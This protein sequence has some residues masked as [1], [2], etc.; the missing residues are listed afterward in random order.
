MKSILPIVV[1]ILALSACNGQ[2][3][4]LV[5]DEVDSSAIILHE[6][7][8]LSVVGDFSGNGKAD[9]IV[10]HN[11]SRLRKTEIDSSPDPQRND[12]DTVVK[13]FYAEDSELFLTS[14]QKMLD[15]L[16]LGVAQGL[17]CLLNL[18]DNNSDGKDEI[19]FV[20]D[21]LDYSNVNSCCI[22][23][24]CNGWEL[25]KSFQINESAFDYG[26]NNQLP[27]ESIQGFL[28]KHNGVWKCCSL[29]VDNTENSM[30]DLEIN[31]CE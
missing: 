21:Y 2:E 20:V 6:L 4:E 12:W 29:S 28:E 8:K 24:W 27:E 30:L 19:A 23:T 7:E 1:I 26:L 11:Y 25:L 16:H 9:T 10:Q 13:W 17:Y 31:R 3:G 18:G 14:T 5:A 22:Y 15:T